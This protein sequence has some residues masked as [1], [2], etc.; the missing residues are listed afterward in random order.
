MH[1]NWFAQAAPCEFVICPH[2]TNNPINFIDPSGHACKKSS[3]YGTCRVDVDW[4]LGFGGNFK[5]KIYDRFNITLVNGGYTDEES[6]EIFY[7]LYKLESGLNN[8]TNMGGLS[9][10]KKNLSET[11]ISVGFDKDPFKN[12]LAFG[13]IPG[14]GFNPHVIGN[15]IFLPSGFSNMIWSSPGGRVDTM[16]IHELGHVVDNR[17]SPFGLGSIL[18]GGAGDALMGFIGARSSAPFGIRFLPKSMIFSDFNDAFTIGNNY[19]YGNESPA[20]YF[21]QLFSGVTMTPND[22]HIPSNASLWMQAYIGLMK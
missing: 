20:D 13:Y 4:N 5:E 15:T 10:M 8:F 11:N 7:A 3:E 9:W 16:I 6:E 21:A 12:Q 1:R 18:G 22:S 17:S 19:E 14:I 2:T